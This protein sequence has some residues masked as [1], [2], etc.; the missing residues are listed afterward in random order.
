MVDLEQTVRLTQAR[1]AAVAEHEA[2]NKELKERIDAIEKGTKDATDS[3]GKWST[4]G[5]AGAL[6]EN[7]AR[8]KAISE[9]RA[10]DIS[11][12]EAAQAKDLA[13][14]LASL[15]DMPKLSDQVKALLENIKKGLG[16]DEIKK[17]IEDI[18]NGVADTAKSAM[19]GAKNMRM[20]STGFGS[21]QSIDDA[22][23]SRIRL[24]AANDA[25][26]LDPK[27][28]EAA[29]L[30][31][32]ERRQVQHQITVLEAIKVNTARRQLAELG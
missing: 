2:R 12:S 4:E 25:N 30:R 5:Q 20:G 19:G 26:R 9:Q 29:R 24:M 21:G 32:E 31:L 23:Q 14:D 1:K 16:F 11:A 6:K 10:K 18:K 15:K 8:Q 13:N 7:Q 22:T 28:N 27:S 17:Q 3:I